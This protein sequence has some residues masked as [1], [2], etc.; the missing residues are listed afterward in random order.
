MK[1][2]NTPKAL[3]FVDLRPHVPCCLVVADVRYADL[4]QG[5]RGPVMV[6]SRSLCNCGG[7]R[8]HD[9]DCGLDGLSSL[10]VPVSRNVDGRFTRFALLRKWLPK[11]GPDESLFSK[12]DRRKAW[13]MVRK[14]LE[15]V[16]IPNKNEDGVA[17]FLCDPTRWCALQS[18][19]RR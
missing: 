4:E 12:L 7:V 5:G 14:D 9:P 6:N 19:H 2:A 18:G 15:R 17:D 10:R 16:G 13:L 1:G 8:I 11:F 3:S